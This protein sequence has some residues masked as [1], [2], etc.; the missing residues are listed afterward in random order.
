LHV[1]SNDEA[2]LRRRVQ[3]LFKANR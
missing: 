2:S 3:L 1:T